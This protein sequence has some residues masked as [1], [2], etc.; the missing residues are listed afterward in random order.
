MTVCFSRNRLSCKCRAPWVYCHVS[1]WPHQHSWSPQRAQTHA[2]NH[3]MHQWDRQGPSTVYAILVI[4]NVTVLK[5]WYRAIPH[6]WTQ[7]V[8]PLGHKI[9]SLLMSRLAACIQSSAGVVPWDSGQTEEILL[10]SQEQVKANSH[11]ID[12]TLHCFNIPR[13]VVKWN[14]YLHLI[15]GIVFVN[16]MDLYNAPRSH[17]HADTNQD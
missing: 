7:K 17:S 14:N 5:H 3:H 10:Q 2:H 6:V 16:A 8:R 15:G 1:G 4:L 12:Y 9:E 11:I 13:Y